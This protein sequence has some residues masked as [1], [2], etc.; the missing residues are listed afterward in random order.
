MDEDNDEALQAVLL[1]DFHEALADLM[2]SS[3]V[4]IEYFAVPSGATA[5]CVGITDRAREIL[6]PLARPLGESVDDLIHRFQ[7]ERVIQCSPATH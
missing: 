6:D 1:R 3:D 4:T 2:A 5:Y 7:A